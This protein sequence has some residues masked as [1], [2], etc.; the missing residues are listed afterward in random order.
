MFCFKVIISIAQQDWGDNHQT[1]LVFLKNQT[2]KKAAYRLPC[3]LYYS[4]VTK[5]F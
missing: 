3:V 1:R 2:I 4:H 5:I